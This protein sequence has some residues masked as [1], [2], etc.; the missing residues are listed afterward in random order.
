MK[1]TETTSK[2]SSYLSL[3]TSVSTLL[4]CALPSLLVMLGMGS[5]VVSVVGELPGLIVLSEH[6]PL[7]FSVSGA[8]LVLGG[9]MQY[10]AKDLPCPID[11]KEKD[12]C[13][14]ARRVS[15]WVYGVSVLLY[16]I[17]FTTAFLLA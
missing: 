1:T 4:C 11:V 6:K 16:G 15:L 14:R 5:V 3:F 17:G 13:A 8:M 7:V 10:R 2:F 9:L 12:A